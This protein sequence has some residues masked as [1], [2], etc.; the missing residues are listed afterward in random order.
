MRQ[1]FHRFESFRFW[2][3]VMPREQGLDH[4]PLKL[5]SSE[6]ET[7]EGVGHAPTQSILDTCKAFHKRLRPINNADGAHIK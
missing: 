5:G 7:A 2:D 3:L 1:L 4:S 6:S